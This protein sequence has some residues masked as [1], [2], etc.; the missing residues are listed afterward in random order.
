[1]CWFAIRMSCLQASGGVK[2]KLLCTQHF[3]PLASQIVI[4]NTD[5]DIEVSLTW[6]PISLWKKSAYRKDIQRNLALT[7]YWWITVS[8]SHKNAKFFVCTFH[9]SAMCHVFQ[10]I[11]C[12]WILLTDSVCSPQRR[13]I[14][15]PFEIFM[16]QWSTSFHCERFFNKMARIDWFALSELYVFLNPINNINT[17]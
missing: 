6:T 17:I 1:M 2:W 14:K 12:Q 11:P 4:H 8:E 13:T 10:F 7:F 9:L 15:F 5:K 16:R 3:Y